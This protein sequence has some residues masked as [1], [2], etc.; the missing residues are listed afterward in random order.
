MGRKTAV[1]AVALAAALCGCDPDDDNASG[2]GPGS[3]PAKAAAP[4][5]PSGEMSLSQ[6]IQLQKAASRMKTDAQG[7]AAAE[8]ALPGGELFDGSRSG[9]GGVPAAIAAQTAYPTGAASEIVGYTAS[10]RPDTL[11]PK[12][13]PPPSSW[14]RLDLPKPDP[15]LGVA[16]SGSVLAAFDAF[17]HKTYQ[18]VAQVFSRRAWGAAA[19]R[20]SQQKHNPNR[21]TVHHT[22]GHKRQDT[23]G[24]VGEMRGMQRFHM[25]GH[26]WN[27]IG[28][29]FVLDGT[30]RVFEGRH[31]DVVGAHVG[32]ANQDNI[33]VAVMGNY[34]RDNLNDE[35]KTSLRRLITFLALRYGSDTARKEFIRGHH[36]Y[37]RTACPGSHI[38]DFLDELSREV[39]GEARTL[40]RG[41]APAGAAASFKPLLIT[42]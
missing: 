31:A 20:G 8:K 28:Y 34:N 6:Q 1:L 16:G 18:A 30:G 24:A 29:H 2:V 14:P 9:L 39:D 35:Q 36:H 41:D 3:G 7:P 26:G 23:T 11:R 37:M 15:A 19:A 13:V 21:V 27:D 17:Q 40:A 38:L 22:V 25:S 10:A 33:G 12:E 32:A 42:N 4:A 5:R